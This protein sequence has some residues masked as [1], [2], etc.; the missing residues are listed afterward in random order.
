MEAVYSSEN[1]VSSYTVQKTTIWTI[2]VKTWKLTHKY[3]IYLKRFEQGISKQEAEDLNTTSVLSKS[4]FYY[5]NQ[6]YFTNNV[7]QVWMKTAI[8]K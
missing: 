3:K 8:S 2:A 4:S 1:L 5:G 6:I 7:T